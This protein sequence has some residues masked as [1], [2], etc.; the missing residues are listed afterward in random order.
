MVLSS[1]FSRVLFNTPMQA[2]EDSVIEA[3]RD[4]DASRYQRVSEVIDKKCP[5]LK[6]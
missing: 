4:N 3:M 2:E 6:K 1:R 5:F